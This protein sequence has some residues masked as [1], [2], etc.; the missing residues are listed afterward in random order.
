MLKSIIPNMY[1][2]S[3]YDID[4][5]ALQKKGIKSFIFDLDNTLVEASCLAA[6]PELIKWFQKIEDMGMQ[7]I[8]VSNN[9]KGRVSHFC[10]PLKVP[11]I[12]TAKKPLSRAF[13]KALKQLDTK[14]Q[15]T[16]VVGDQLLTD[17]LGGNRMGLYTILV[18]PM[19]F[20]AEGFWT[21]MNRKMERL[22]FWWMKKH[23][24]LRWE[25]NN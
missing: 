20:E 5:V 12:Y 4:L 23:G 10:H 17:I 24:Y 9:S 2:Q 22:F 15:E 11:F 1:V 21:R 18:V 13:R 7:V 3:I 14:K 16:V 6:T 8:I 19:S 25:D